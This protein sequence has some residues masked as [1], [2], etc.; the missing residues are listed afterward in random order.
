MESWNINLKKTFFI[1]FLS[2]FFIFF[3]FS[4]FS[5]EG[6]WK[7][8]PT[9][10]LVEYLISSMNNEE[11]LSQVLM[12]GYTGTQPS[13]IIMEWIRERNIGGVK[14]FG[15]NVNTLPE[16]A[17]SIGEMQKTALNT[18]QKIPLLIATDQEGGWVRHVKGDTSITPGNMAIGATGLSHDAYYTGFYIGLELKALGINMNFAPTVDVYINPDADV[19]GPRAFSDDPVTT[20]ILSVAYFKGLDKAGVI[21]TAKHFP[22]HGNADKDSHGALPIIHSTL[23]DLWNR[24]AV[25]YRFLIKEGLP[26][27]MS[28]H[29]AFPEIIGNNTPSSL[30]GFF[31]EELLKEKLG[32]S[33]IVITD[34]LFMNGV[35]EIGLDTPYICIRA[36]EAGNDMIMLSRTPELFSDIWKELYSQFTENPGFRARVLDAVRRI[37]RIKIAYLKNGSSVPLIPDVEKIKESVPNNEGRKFFFDLSCRSVTIIR[38]KDIPLDKEKSGR[39]L[40]AGQFRAFLEE[41]KKR[42]PDADEFYFPYSPFYWA[43]D[44]DTKKL[45]QISRQYDT[46]IFCLANPNS[47]EVLKSLENEEINLIVFSVLTPIYLR[48]LPRIQSALAVYGTGRDSFQSGFAVLM[49]DFKPEGTLPLKTFKKLELSL[50]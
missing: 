44:A 33:G 11:L 17:K 28:G 32:F 29:L 23:D 14:I 18:N 42:L 6:F 46:V 7:N 2:F 37:L 10:E 38:D 1:L 34:D 25:P 40:L 8:L 30:H 9:D 15:W 45:L 13:D 4:G 16:L 5:E 48:E 36:L 39:I 26:A 41:G 35:Q 43:R 24:D 50:E 20:G 19:I 49:G 27:I 3:S 22:G 21:S 31:Q 12:L 47:L